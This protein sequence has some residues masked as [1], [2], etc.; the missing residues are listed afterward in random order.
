MRIYTAVG[1]VAFKTFK[2][3]DG[4][5]HFELLTTPPAAHHVRI[6]T[7]LRSA[8]DLLM[9]LLAIE[10]LRTYHAIDLDIR[11]LL[12]AR[13]DRPINERTPFTLDVIARV[14]KTL[15][16]GQIRILDCHSKVGLDTLNATNVLP[17]EIVQSILRTTL[18]RVVAPDAGAVPRVAAMTADPFVY[19]EKHR[20]SPTG[21]LS[22]FRIDQ[23][24]ALIPGRHCLIVDDICDGGG[25][26][27]GLAKVLREYGA[28]GVS[29]YVTHGIF[30]KGVVLDGI[31][32]IYTTDS[33]FTKP[34]HWP[35]QPRQFPTVIPV[36]MAQLEG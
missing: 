6:E 32:Q 7:A 22:G 10:T 14:L 3:P 31:D 20:D 17:T 13:M 21:K 12:G 33:Y 11:Y 30:S 4:Q 25:T 2:F 8:D 18:M 28:T 34:D 5:P 36:S 29:L 1:D 27:S 16:V 26:F 15:P 9:L 35:E 19:A 24:A 23:N